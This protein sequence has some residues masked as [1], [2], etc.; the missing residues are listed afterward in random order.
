MKKRLLSLTLIGITV[1]SLFTGCGGSE[2]D[3][4]AETNSAVGSNYSMGES[5]SYND[6]YEETASYDSDESSLDYDSAESEADIVKNNMMIAKDVNISID[7]EDVDTFDTDI[8]AKVEQFSGY[9]EST[10]ITNFNNEWETYRY[11]YYTMRIPSEKLEDFLTLVDGAGLVTSKTIEAEDV[12]LE[13]VDIQAHLTAL[14]NERN[15]LNR[16]QDMA[17]SLSEILDIQD[18]LSSVQAQLDSY[19]R[20]K[21]LLQGRVKYSKVKLT[22]R[23]ERNIEHPIRQVFDVQFGKKLLDGLGAAFEV[24][25]D[26]VVAIPVIIVIIFF[27][28]LFIFIMIKVCRKVFKKKDTTANTN[29]P[30][31]EDSNTDKVKDEHDTTDKE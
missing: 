4:Y 30:V 31:Y 26:I 18:R 22:A 17:V 9:F 28:I 15:N 20:Q 13:Y 12:S 19:E 29:V 5:K 25:V 16:L 24:F 8:K 7:V 11:G 27:I 23:Q 2:S 6:S 14:E 21:L 1:I 10:E 3:S